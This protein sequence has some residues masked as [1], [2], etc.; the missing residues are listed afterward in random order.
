[1][2]WNCLIDFL[3]KLGYLKRC[4]RGYLLDLLSDFFYVLSEKFYVL[5]DFLESLSN[6]IHCFF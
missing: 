4:W 1:M 3:G 5:F 2:C 6:W